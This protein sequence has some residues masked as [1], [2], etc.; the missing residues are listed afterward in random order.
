MA[1]WLCTSHQR[2]RAAKA[3]LRGSN[4]GEATSPSQTPLS[5]SVTASSSGV[6]EKLLPLRPEIGKAGVNVEDQ[7]KHGILFG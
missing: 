2:P 1:I 6:S 3:L 7:D 4:P 5:A